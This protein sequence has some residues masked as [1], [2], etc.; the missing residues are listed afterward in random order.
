MSQGGTIKGKLD[1]VTKELDEEMEHWKE[2][3]LPSPDNIW[4][5]NEDE[6]KHHCHLE[7]IIQIIKDKFEMS[8]D[9]LNLY[10][11]T[12]VL[13]EMRT[14]RQGAATLRRQALQQDILRGVLPPNPQ[15]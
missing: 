6:F 15:I 4:R 11:R 10:L 2:A 7:A 13:E 8:E 5:M 3:R 1:A 9:E 14:I 12:T